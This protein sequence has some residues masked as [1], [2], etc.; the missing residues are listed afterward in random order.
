[1]AT[2]IISLQIEV[3]D[4]DVKGA[5]K[6]LGG[7]K[8]AA[9]NTGTANKELGELENSLNGVGAGSAAA[10][11][12][13][14]RLAAAAGPVGAAL[15]V[16]A[17]AIAAVAVAAFK[18]GRE[19][20]ELSKKYAELGEELARTSRE[21]GVSAE[22]LSALRHQATLTGT[23]FSQVTSAIDAFTQKVV[24]ASAGS[25]DARKTL[26]SL[27]ITGVNAATDVDQ[28]LSKALETLAE[29]PEGLE[30]AKAA[31]D[32]FG[33]S[34]AK[35][36]PLLDEFDG[37][38]Q[39]LIDSAD[40]FG[41]LIGEDNVRDSLAFQRAMREN[42]QHVEGLKN[43]FIKG[44]LPVITEVFEKFNSLLDENSEK[45]KSWVRTGAWA[46][47]ATIAAIEN[48]IDTFTT[49]VDLT[50]R[51]PG[52]TPGGAA[53]EIRKLWSRINKRIERASSLRVS[54]SAAFE[55]LPE[56]GPSSES[57]G[58]SGRAGREPKL[59][60]LERVWNWRDL[61]KFAEERGFIV[62]STTGG[63]HNV[64]SLHPQG[65]AIDIRTRDKTA[66]QIG[67]FIAQ[68]LAAGIRVVDERLR[69]PGQRVWRGE[70]LHLEEN[71]TR[72]SFFNRGLGFG[73][74]TVEDL[75]ALDEARRMGATQF[76]DD[77]RGRAEQLRKQR[78]QQVRDILDRAQGT[79]TEI[80]TEAR[81][82][83]GDITPR[84]TLNSVE[85]ERMARLAPE[86]FNRI[87]AEEDRRVFDAGIFGERGELAATEATFKR[88]KDLETEFVES[89]TQSVELGVRR[90]HLSLSETHHQ[91]IVNSMLEEARIF[92]EE[93][94]D[95]LNKQLEVHLAL[96]SDGLFRQ[97]EAEAQVLREK[98]R[99]QQEIFGL[100]TL[101]ATQGANAAE[102]YRKAWL[103]AIYEIRDEN[104]RAVEDQIRA[105]VRLGD[106]QTVHNDQIRAKVLGHLAAQKS[107]TETIG[108]EII[109]L[110]EEI[111]TRSEEILDRSI[112][113]IP[114]LGGLAKT[115]ARQSLS[116]FT[117][118]ILD[119]FFPGSAG[120]IEAAQ[121]PELGELKRHT[122][123]L[124]QIAANT[125][126]QAVSPAG[127]ITFNADL[128][129]IAGAGASAARHISVSGSA[130]PQSIATLIGGGLANAIEQAIR[131]PGLSETST[132]SHSGLGAAHPGGV[133]AAGTANFP[134][135]AG[136][137]AGI[138]GIAGS[139]VP[140][141]IGGII[142]S[143][144]AGIGIA[145]SLGTIL[146]ISA[147]G[148]PIGLAIGAAI[149][150]VT[151]IAGG[152]F[153]SKK[154]KRDKQEKI[155]QLMQGFTDAIQEF[156]DLITQVR[157]FSIDPDQAL[158]RGKELRQQI[159]SG[160]GI[161]FE[162]KKYRRIARE[163]IN[164]QLTQID[165]KPDGLMEQLM[166]AAA[167]AKAAG[168]RRQRIL[169]EFAGGVFMD[170]VFRAQF[171]A[172]K[173]KNG[174]LPGSWSGVDRVPA[175]LADAEMVLNPAQQRNVIA[176]AGGRDV[177]SG[178]GIPNY[179][180]KVRSAPA[181]HTMNTGGL[182]R[183]GQSESSPLV[184]QPNF[185]FEIQGVT[186]EE[187]AR[188][189]LQSDDGRRTLVKVI[190]EEI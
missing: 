25:N 106:M 39:A 119:K 140:G 37:D 73:G 105:Q 85:I 169:P 98:L 9:R 153:G 91:K 103:E 29:M 126:I 21:T 61:K 113:K 118:G 47:E 63:K 128:G 163:R 164:Q 83:L 2:K 76:I 26:E 141:R 166:D 77:P 180:S 185:K 142:S 151:A 137:V 60:P 130:G 40:K 156:R 71:D 94:L 82:S 108:D 157:T 80:S 134:R 155:P 55:G 92:Q 101:I 90:L 150:L 45:L 148:G 57:G 162:S 89:R 15:A 13:M 11:G 75:A 46:A 72:A 110:Y 158:S 104:I 17:V 135:L 111:A 84:T 67:E 49:L 87:S 32:A 152:L 136:N 74:R 112:G 120:K 189:W 184:L 52:L 182:V 114:I 178:A 70:H 4:K 97:Y 123:I 6:S 174:L 145:S 181:V 144:G 147:L 27:G 154:K 138:L 14:G 50:N 18:A 167:I 115:L 139:V 81:V 30:R 56:R 5:E 41:T 176:N 31:N 62:R 35:L 93:E 22:S 64:G 179:E 66:Q 54:A 59:S 42:Q 187:G 100:E 127:N 33:S 24:D 23:E 175:L 79:P 109:G 133:P 78:I 165:A 12:G 53:E 38:L 99:L 116:S 125:A 186:F 1:M 8:T 131:Q 28:A 34:G 149:G 20:L 107:I 16:A 122:S 190:R 3:D 96:T 188:V 7:L 58:R 117:I 160:F 86:L 102:R 159:A 173:R 172:F 177:F 69:P 124:E 143:I 183:S 19:I 129:G 171:G 10:A 44:F 146:S 121:N 161:Q 68:A 51:L 132:T 43:E 168:D 36:L 65:L 88:I 48:Q 170:A 95:T